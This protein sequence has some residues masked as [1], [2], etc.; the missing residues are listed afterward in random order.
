MSNR[1]RWLGVGLIVL[2]AAV[3]ALWPRST[4]APAGS[5][6]PPGAGAQDLTAARANAA[7]D[8]CPAAPGGPA[9]LAGVRVHCLADGSTVDLG[10]ALA[11]RAALVNVWATWCEPCRAELPVLAAYTT[12][13]GAL[14]VL[15]LAVQS[16][17]AGALDLLTRLHVRFAN[18]LDPDGVAQRAIKAPDALP[19]S[20]VIGADGSVRFVAD[21]RVFHSVDQVRQTVDR[22]LPAG[23]NGTP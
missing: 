2:T 10:G 4:P 15:G 13:P 8:H 16:D 5:A 21:P 12:A 14:P 20:F 22:Y 7:L 1:T 6:A 11:G 9:T 3:I 17:P 18:L 23:R 19:A